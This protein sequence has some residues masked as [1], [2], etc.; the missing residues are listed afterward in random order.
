MNRKY[1]LSIPAR[2][3][4][5]WLIVL[6]ASPVIAVAT[7]LI[8]GAVLGVSGALVLILVGLVTRPVRR[9]LPAGALVPFV[10]ITAVVLISII[11]LLIQ[12]LDPDLRRGLGIYL[13]L[14][15][16]SCLVMALAVEP[17]I[18][19]EDG[20]R[21]RV[22]VF[23]AIQYAALVCALGLVREAFGHGTILGWP[24]FGAGFQGS[25]VLFLSQAP[26]GFMALGC[27]AGLYRLVRSR[28]RA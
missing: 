13:P 15:A 22:L 25:P 27:G 24:L 12:A 16:V 1:P 19:N 28:H 11:G 26:G 4:P 7:N 3:T 18:K 2:W 23:P 9:S 21:A 14:Q 5:F 17:E 6:G 10:M 20:P 8:Q